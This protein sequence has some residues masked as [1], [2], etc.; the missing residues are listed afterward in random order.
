M[1]KK[2][3]D[4]SV[5]IDAEY[6]NLIFW[7]SQ[8]CSTP[9]LRG[10]TIMNG[11]HGDGGGIVVDDCSPVISDCVVYRC[12]AS[13][14]GGGMYCIDG[15]EPVLTDVT[16]KYCKADIGAGIC[17]IGSTPSLTRVRFEVGTAAS[18]GGGVYCESAPGA[19]DVTDCVFG[20][21]LA[22]GE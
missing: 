10:L 17:S 22:I 8:Y 1:A 7:L 3:I 18:R 5:T 15:A 9:V 12:R 13:G 6:A 14:H 11:T 16:F 19:V 21:S 4:L 2:F 20:R